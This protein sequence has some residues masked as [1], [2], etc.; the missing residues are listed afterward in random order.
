MT[1][2]TFRDAGPKDI[3]ITDAAGTWKIEPH[4]HGESPIYVRKPNGETLR[5]IA[6]RYEDH[7][8]F[9]LAQVGKSG[10]HG[11]TGTVKPWLSWTGVAIQQDS[12]T[13]GYPMLVI[14]APDSTRVITNGHEETSA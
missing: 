9:A 12:D 10:A 11:I 2:V 6:S 14:E 13:E 3:G 1:T 4:P 8:A 5:V 7:W